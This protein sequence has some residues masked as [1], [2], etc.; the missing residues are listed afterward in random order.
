M[1][2]DKYSEFSGIL[3]NGELFSANTNDYTNRAGYNVS[4]ISGQNMNMTTGKINKGVRKGMFAD[5]SDQ[6]W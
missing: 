2:E 6:D 4:Y 5:G 3:Q 1:N